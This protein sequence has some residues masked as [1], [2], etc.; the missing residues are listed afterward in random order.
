MKRFISW[1]VGATLLMI[2]C[3][4][5][6]VTF[7]GTSGMAIC[8]ILFFALNPAFS[9]VCGVFAGMNI[10]KFWSLPIISAALFLTGA[11]IFFDLGEPDFL[12]YSTAYLV[13]GAVA[14]I[15]TAIIKRI[16]HQR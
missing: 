5:L 15:L 16:K 3:P 12:L 9:A 7:A 1:I 11:W 8:F 2:G 14:M 6:A 10:K 13:I 4:F